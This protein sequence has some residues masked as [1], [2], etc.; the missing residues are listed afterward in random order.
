MEETISLINLEIAFLTYADMGRIHDRKNVY[1]Y[2][3]RDINC[4]HVRDFLVRNGFLKL[5]TVNESI[6]YY[7]YREMQKLLK[8]TGGK[9]G[10]TKAKMTENAWKYLTQKELEE[11]FGYSCYIPTE[12]AKNHIDKNVDYYHVD[13][14][15]DQ[16]KNNH[17]ERYDYYTQIDKYS[18]LRMYKNGDANISTECGDN[19]IL[20]R[21]NTCG[22]RGDIKLFDD[23]LYVQTFYLVDSIYFLNEEEF[24]KR[25]LAFVTCEVVN[26][27][28]TCVFYDCNMHEQFKKIRFGESPWNYILRNGLDFLREPQ[29]SNKPIYEDKTGYIM[30]FQKVERMIKEQNGVYDQDGSINYFFHIPDQITKIIV[31]QW[32]SKKIKVEEIESVFGTDSDENYKISIPENE[33]KYKYLILWMFRERKIVIPVLNGIPIF[34]FCGYRNNQYSHFYEN[35]DETK[36]R[37]QEELGANNDILEMFYKTYPVK[38]LVDYDYYKRYGDNGV[39]DYRYVC[40]NFKEYEQKYNNIIL[41]LKEQKILPIRWIN[42]FKLYLLVKSYFEGA[43]FQY[44]ADWL[45]LQSLDIYIPSQ[46]IGIEYQGIQHYEAVDYFGGEE[47][48]QDVKKRDNIKLEKCQK[49]DIVLLYWEYSVEINEINLKKLLE[50]INV[51]I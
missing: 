38:V 48:L 25:L 1:P 18:E 27:Q 35:Y 23:D 42:E 43:I 10:N 12:K 31:T 2:F 20:S 41:E 19:L 9:A 24:G 44:K 28:Y 30:Y 21:D 11:Y 3:L 40:D 45:D 4:I 37:L 34:C 16:L 46:R 36:K 6:P 13:M 49:Q 33:K 50:T 29:S 22:I 47:G 7:P 51:I 14:Q 17:Q 15:L 8:K 39:W 32:L 26:E 5:A